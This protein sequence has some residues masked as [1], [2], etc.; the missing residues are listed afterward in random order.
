MSRKLVVLASQARAHNVNNPGREHPVRTRLMFL[1]ALIG[2][3][4]AVEVSL[5]AAAAS[6]KPL[7]TKIACTMSLPVVAPDSATR[8]GLVR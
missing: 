4:S 6:G 8:F 2:V 1:V 3:S 7:T 5:G